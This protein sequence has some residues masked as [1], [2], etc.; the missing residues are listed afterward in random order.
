MIT[1]NLKELYSNLT[2]LLWTLDKSR[3]PIIENDLQ[4][5]RCFLVL[6]LKQLFILR[7][8]LIPVENFF[9]NLPSGTAKYQDSRRNVIDF[10]H[11]ISK[12]L[13]VQ[14]VNLLG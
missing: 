4:F 12:P 6:S 5:G 10:F 14:F 9:I 13:G 11:D 1:N 2:K 3:T 8:L 7:K